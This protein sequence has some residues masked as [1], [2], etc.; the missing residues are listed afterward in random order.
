MDGAGERPAGNRA[1]RP[2]RNCPQWTTGDSG[3]RRPFPEGQ[4]SGDRL[5]RYRSGGAGRRGVGLGLSTFAGIGL[6]AL[7]LAISDEPIRLGL[8]NIAG[9]SGIAAVVVLLVTALS[10]PVLWRLMRPDGLRTE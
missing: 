1:P 9:I 3:R 5:R 10:L 7:L 8:A 4:P 6:G 2:Q